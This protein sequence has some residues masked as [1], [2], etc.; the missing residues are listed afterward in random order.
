MREKIIL[1][2]MAC[3]VILPVIFMLTWPES[4]PDVDL[5]AGEI[6][7]RAIAAHGGRQARGAL[8]SMTRTL[9]KRIPGKG[10]QQ[11]NLAMIFP[12]KFRMD[13]FLDNGDLDFSWVYSSP[14]PWKLDA[15]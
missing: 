5:D 12:D 10:R 8:E 1:T 4:R 2:V 6:L 7:E 11:A 13:V 14:Y 15:G 3:L 9:C